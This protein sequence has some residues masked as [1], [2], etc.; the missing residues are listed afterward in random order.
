MKVK[1]SYGWISDEPLE[2]GGTLQGT[3]F[4]EQEPKCVWI[5]NDTHVIGESLRDA[6]AFA[7]GKLMPETET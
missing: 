6:A 4:F 7:N 3:M 2:D 1:R 5:Y